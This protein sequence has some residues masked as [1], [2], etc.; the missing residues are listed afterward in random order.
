MQILIKLRKLLMQAHSKTEQKPISKERLRRKL[1][2]GNESGIL[3]QLTLGELDDNNHFLVAISTYDANVLSLEIVIGH[4]TRMMLE[5]RGVD[6]LY[7]LAKAESTEFAGQ[8][9]AVCA[10][11]AVNQSLNTLFFTLEKV[12]KEDAPK[13]LS[14]LAKF[15][16]KEGKYRGYCMVH[17]A[18]Q[19]GQLDNLKLLQKHGANLM[20][21]LPKDT[22]LFTTRDDKKISFANWSILDLA[23][24]QRSRDRSQV[25]KAAFDDVIKLYMQCCDSTDDEV[26]NDIKAKHSYLSDDQFEEIEQLITPGQSKRTT[27]DIKG[28]TAKAVVAMTSVPKKRKVEQ[29]EQQ[30]ETIADQPTIHSP[31]ERKVTDELREIKTLAEQRGKEI[32]A[33]KA[34]LKRQQDEHHQEKAK[35]ARAL[36]DKTT[37]AYKLSLRL[38]KEEERNINIDRQQLVHREEVH[39]LRKENL[40]LQGELRVLMGAGSEDKFSE[41]DDITMSADFSLSMPMP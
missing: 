8:T 23:V 3:N 38:V 22:E 13:I 27:R 21:V 11:G 39:R 28:S 15:K 25:Q 41:D 12:L 2:W 5:K 14:S 26:L 35:L 37:E 19:T 17:A 33:L 36:E 24:E 31:V 20:A 7:E 34:E 1:Q 16:I 29:K 6:H 40:L 10:A 32:E 9:I 30:S 4:L 18:G